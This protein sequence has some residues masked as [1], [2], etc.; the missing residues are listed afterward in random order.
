MPVDDPAELT[1]W[2]GRRDHHTTGNVLAMLSFLLAGAILLGLERWAWRDSI[3]PHLGLVKR[4]AVPAVVLSHQV[5]EQGTGPQGSTFPQVTYRYFVSGTAYESST[6]RSGEYLNEDG[7]I[8]A[9][10]FDG[11]DRHQLVQ[12]LFDQFSVGSTVTAWVDLHNPNAAMLVPQQPSFQPFLW[13]LMP[14][15]F[16]PILWVMVVGVLRI[17]FQR[18][19][20]RW[21][22]MWRVCSEA[23]NFL[24]L[25]TV[26]NLLSVPNHRQNKQTEKLPLRVGSKYV[27]LFAAIGGDRYR[28]LVV[29]FNTWVDSL[30]SKKCLALWQ[31]RMP[32]GLCD[33]SVRKL[34]YKSVFHF[35]VTIRATSRWHVQANLLRNLVPFGDFGRVRGEAKHSGEA[36]QR[37]QNDG[38]HR[39]DHEQPAEWIQCG[40]CCRFVGKNGVHGN[41]VVKHRDYSERN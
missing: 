29:D 33:D 34:G 3:E 15:L 6:I 4:T 20:G 22:A 35:P 12:S 30:H 16:V 25:S 10:R 40:R 21:L 36:P 7:E 39:A 11:P 28:L 26:T 13:A 5:E 24:R 18:P 27:A 38:T 37:E 2:P 1:I 8:G 17:F 19:R 32:T 23:G 41:D 31:A 14:A 9:C